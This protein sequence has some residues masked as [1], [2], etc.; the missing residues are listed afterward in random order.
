MALGLATHIAEQMNLT[1][2]VDSAGTLMIEGQPAA[3]H[4]VSV[5]LDIG[6][7]IENHR[8]KGLTET[9][10]TWA[11]YI[12]VMESKHGQFIQARFPSHQNKIIYL[13]HLIGQIEVPD[14]VGRWKRAFKTNR[15]M[16]QLS[17]K[18]FLEKI[19]KRK[20]KIAN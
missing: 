15:D 20:S 12:L 8:S 7:N 16:L 5:C 2:D 1:L 6:V 10:C 9:H 19:E 13:G 17:I 18:T 4:A 14:P 11:D 3:T